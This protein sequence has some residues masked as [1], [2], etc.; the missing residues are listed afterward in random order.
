MAA[1]AG[2]PW[3][4]RAIVGA[5]GVANGM[6]SIAA[7]AS[8]MQLAG[9]GRERRE[10]T[11]VGLWGAAQAIAFGVGGMAG[12]A[13]SDLA[14]WWLSETGS[15]YAA[16]FGLESVLFIA[17]AVMAR[18]VT[19]LSRTSKTVAHTSRAEAVHQPAAVVAATSHHSTASAGM[20]Q[21]QTS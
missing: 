8:M 20:A 14:R 18:Q 4:L 17:S 13:A 6:F 5:M 2:P 3:P 9:Q 12:A 1:V 7:I 21:P 10:G 16:V 19:R 11:R 15:A